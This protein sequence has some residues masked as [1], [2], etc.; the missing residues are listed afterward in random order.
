MAWMKSWP[1]K[2]GRS[3]RARTSWL[4]MAMPPGLGGTGLLPLGQDGAGAVEQ[5]EPEADG[6]GAV[7]R[8]I[9]G[10]D[11][12]GVQAVPALVAQI[13]EEGVVGG[14]VHAVQVA[15]GVAEH[16]VGQAHLVQG[17]DR[18]AGRDHVG[19]AGLYPP[20]VEGGDQQCG[21]LGARKVGQ[22]LGRNACAGLAEVGHVVD[23]GL[24]GCGHGGVKGQ[25]GIAHAVRV[26]DGQGPRR[27]QAGGEAGHGLR[28]DGVGERLV[29]HVAAGPRV[30]GLDVEH[31]CTPAAPLPARA[32]AGVQCL[33]CAGSGVRRAGV[34]PANG[35]WPH[36]PAPARGQ[37][38]SALH[39]RDHRG[40]GPENGAWPALGTETGCVGSAGRR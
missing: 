40:A 3:K 15:A 23:V 7:A 29:E 24:A 32:G 35:P 34:R 36:G 13:S 28:S 26:I 8:P 38:A 5:A 10:G 2:A 4:S 21:G 33:A 30:E 17:Q 19:D 37:R 16:P 14:E 20:G 1:A 39:V 18:H 12:A 25:Q 9:V 22:R 6:G 11:Q 31:C 27:A